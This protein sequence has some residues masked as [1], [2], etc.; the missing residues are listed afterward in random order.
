MLSVAQPA[1]VHRRR[2]PRRRCRAC[3]DDSGRVGVLILRAIRL[4]RPLVPRVDTAV[5]EDGTA[6]TVR[7]PVG[8][9]R[10]TREALQLQLF[11][12]RA[13]AQRSN[14]SCEGMADC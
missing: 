9:T 8:S 3:Q 6:T 13:I 10:M 14:I 7:D 1:G 12:A 4:S 2:R 11:L 5:G